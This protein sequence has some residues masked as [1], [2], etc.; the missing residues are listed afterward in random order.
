MFALILELQTSTFAIA[1]DETVRDGLQ[2]LIAMEMLRQHREGD[3][4]EAPFHGPVFGNLKAP[5]NLKMRSTALSFAHI[6][7]RKGSL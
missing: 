5:A 4:P 2:P 6:T 1:C 3:I 7:N